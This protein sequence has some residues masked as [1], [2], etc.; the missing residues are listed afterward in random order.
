MAGVCSLRAGMRSI[1]NVG[2]GVGNVR[3]KDIGNGPRKDGR[4][5]G[6]YPIGTESLRAQH[7]HKRRIKLNIGGVRT[8]PS[9]G[10]RR[11]DSS[12]CV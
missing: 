5:R 8:V 1:N 3:D 9:C 10:K 4:V 12:A 11:V 6:T 2:D 7:M